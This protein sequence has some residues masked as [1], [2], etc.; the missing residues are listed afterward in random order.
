MPI[1]RGLPTDAPANVA[2]RDRSNAAL[3]RELGT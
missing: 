2:T 3:A 1:H